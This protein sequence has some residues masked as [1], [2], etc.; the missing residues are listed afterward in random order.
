MEINYAPV[1]HCSE[2]PIVDSSNQ[3]G[4]NLSFMNEIH[5]E[6]LFLFILKI[7]LEK[8]EVFTPLEDAE[9]DTRA[10]ETFLNVCISTNNEVVV[11]KLDII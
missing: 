9:I 3:S 5:A 10:D 2:I 1:L 11:D 8:D 7:L 4:D 6:A